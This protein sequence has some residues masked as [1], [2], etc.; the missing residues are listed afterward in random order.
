MNQV[1]IIGASAVG[2]ITARECASRGI[3]TTV[4]E[5]HNTVGKFGKCTGLYSYKGRKLIRAEHQHLALNDLYGGVVKA[6]SQEIV[7]RRRTPQAAVFN[8][9][10]FDVACARDAQNAGARILLS[11]PAT[12]IKHD[13][14]YHTTTPNANHPS[15]VL[16]GADGAQSFTAK[17]LGFPSIP[18]N[19]FVL[20]W[21]AE[22]EGANI[23]DEKLVDVILDPVNFPGFFAWSVPT[24]RNSVKIGFGTSR[25]TNLRPSITTL[26]ARP[27]VK[28]TLAK[29]VKK[30]EFAALIPLAVRT[31]TQKQN[32]LLVGDAAGQVKATTGGGVVFG[33]LCAHLAASSVADY[34]DGKALDYET[35]WR[36]KYE[37]PLK[38]HASLRRLYNSLDENLLHAGMTLARLGGFSH[39]AQKTADM[40]FVFS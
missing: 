18:D 14:V 3:Q 20:A 9:E 23:E 2:L 1:T 7:I 19:K 4:L 16:V 34:F 31:Q 10:E 36:A 26:L 27:D 25:K 12:A 13:F 24:S 6:G 17:S 22:Y 29:A 28:N 30:R 33:G 35:R 32:C 8:R 11:Q 5:E 15:L 39:F 40:D 37:K 21:E 38:T